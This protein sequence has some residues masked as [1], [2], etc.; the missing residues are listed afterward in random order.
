MMLRFPPRRLPPPRGFA[1]TG[2]LSSDAG[3]ARDGLRER[4]RLGAGAVVVEAKW[5]TAVSREATGS[6]RRGVR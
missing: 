2:D 5:V 3:H 4:A 1:F 6:S